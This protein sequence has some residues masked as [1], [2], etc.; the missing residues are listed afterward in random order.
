MRL[1]GAWKATDLRDKLAQAAEADD[2][3]DALRAAAIDG[4]ARMGDDA[5]RETLKKLSV[6]PTPAKIRRAAIG[7]LAAIDVRGAARAATEMLAAGDDNAR[8]V[9]AAPLNRATAAAAP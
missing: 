8:A 5:S 3:A 2:T 6:A 7:G 9:L 1:A 4:L